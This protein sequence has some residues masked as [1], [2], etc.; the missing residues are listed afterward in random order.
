MRALRLPA[1]SSPTRTHWPSRPSHTNKQVQFLLGHG[2]DAAATQPRD[3]KG[4][5]E[6]AVE[7]DYVEVLKS[8]FAH[9]PCKRRHVWSTAAVGGSR[10]SRSPPTLTRP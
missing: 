6:L 1:A 8:L 10:C 9:D 5:L 2:A 4:A 3:G 7:G